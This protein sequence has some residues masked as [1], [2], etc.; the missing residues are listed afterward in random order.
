[1]IDP[2]KFFLGNRNNLAT[3]KASSKSS[4]KSSHSFDSLQEKDSNTKNE[5]K[6]DF[7]FAQPKL[8]KQIDQDPPLLLGLKSNNI[9][10]FENLPKIQL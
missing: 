5:L 2:R 7:N 9:E 1:M 10:E 6:I 8:N 4:I 3:P